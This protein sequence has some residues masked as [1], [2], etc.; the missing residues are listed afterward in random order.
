MATLE[1]QQL[2]EIIVNTRRKMLTMGGAALAALAFGG[3]TKAQAQS[4]TTGDQDILN[5]ALNLEYL[6]AQF[7]NLAVS[8]V[9]IDQLP[10]PIPVAVNGGTAGSV[11]VKSNPKVPF[12]SSI[13]RSYAAE[14]ATEEGK[15]VL[16]LQKTLGSVAVSMPDINLLD[17]FNALAAL[18]G[19]G[20][21]FDP[22]ANDANFLIGAYIFEDVGVTAYH[23]AAPLITDKTG[24][25]PAAVGIHAVEAYHA[26]LVR[27]TINAVDA[28][29]QFAPVG[30]LIGYT[31]AISAA[32]SSL[33]NPDPK[34]PIT[35]PFTTF[36]NL[37]ADDQGV[38]TTAVSL[39]GSSASFTASTIADTDVNALGFGRSTT[40][41]LAIVTGNPATATSFQG[42]FF[43]SGLNGNIA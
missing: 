17:S 41:I 14:T 29:A 26:G 7:Y 15:H 22:F 19:I 6:E 8:G 13:I 2:D 23:G 24:I 18:A 16:F 28:S 21:T 36:A 4:T 43:P 9:T 27:T 34:N 1:T 32:R 37:T 12:S 33:A 3:T 42:A 31:Q 20:S 35:S 30:T 11:T 39:N 10:T 38:Q 25:L 5:F 40:Q